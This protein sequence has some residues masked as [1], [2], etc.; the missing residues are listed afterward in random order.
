MSVRTIDIQTGFRTWYFLKTK[1]K[2]YDQ[3]DSRTNSLV[4][5]TTFSQTTHQKSS[6]TYVLKL[7]P[8]VLRERAQIYCVSGFCS[9]CVQRR[10]VEVTQAAQQLITVLSVEPNSVCHSPL[11][12][13]LT[14]KNPVPE[15]SYSFLNTRMQKNFIYLSVVTLREYV[16]V[17]IS[18]EKSSWI[19]CQRHTSY[20]K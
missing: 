3:S 1:R 14:R 4:N 16:S 17:T 7:D 12:H 18:L 11:F 13:V 5:N 9:S 19:S 20:S 2:I 15:T 8:T 6:R 10:T